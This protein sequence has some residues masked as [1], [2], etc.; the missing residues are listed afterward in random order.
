MPH[1][2]DCSPVSSPLEFPDLC[3]IEDTLS[4]ADEELGTVCVDVWR[5][6]SRNDLAANV[7]W[8][9]SIMTTADAEDVLTPRPVRGG[10]PVYLRGGTA[11]DPLMNFEFQQRL[12]RFEFRYRT[13][14]D[15]A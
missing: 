9:S 7:S 3:D 5:G 13:E 10:P 14:G 1:S 12:V 4:L 15:T 6:N 8:N 11:F 2:V